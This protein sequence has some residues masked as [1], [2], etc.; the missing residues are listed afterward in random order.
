[1]TAS[2]G[3]AKARDFLTTLRDKNA[4]TKEQALGEYGI[5]S[6]T[7]FDGKLVMVRSIADSTGVSTQ[8]LAR[9]A[10][11]WIDIGDTV[12][13][14]PMRGGAYVAV[15]IGEFEG[16]IMRF[17]DGGPDSGGPR[18][19]IIIGDGVTGTSPSEFEMRID[20]FYGADVPSPGQ[21]DPTPVETM[22]DNE[23]IAR[24][25][26]WHS[27]PA[28]IP[29]GYASVGRA[30][31][32]GMVSSLGPLVGI[33]LTANRC[34]YIPIFLSETQV[35]DSIQFEITTNVSTNQTMIGWYENAAGGFGPDTRLAVGAKTTQSSA[36][37]KTHNLTPDN[38]TYVGGRWYWAAFATTHATGLRGSNSGDYLPN[39]K[40]WSSSS[41]IT[42]VICMMYEELGSGWT[43]LPVDASPANFI[44]QYVH[45]GAVRG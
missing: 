42:D 21:A 41:S 37:I 18:R 40:G 31:N 30:N 11:P 36:G 44:N 26:H 2:I 29:V 6:D 4:A 45:L 35:I 20:V 32:L 24:S 22:G 9:A 16:P 43:T 3:T 12:A 5:V 1:L 7:V 10:G 28:N 14:F 25:D 23:S 38:Q 17:A 33:T 39:L 15:K 34:Y 8:R 19:Y 27:V 13:L